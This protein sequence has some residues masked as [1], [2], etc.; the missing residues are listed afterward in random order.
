MNLRKWVLMN[1]NI[2]LMKLVYEPC[3]Q[4][5]IVIANSATEAL[6]IGVK[7][8]ELPEEELDFY[9]LTDYAN[10][11]VKPQTLVHYNW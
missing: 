6:Q 8:F 2:H 9:N 1:M 5:I 4:K 11:Q 3:L 7:E 10:S